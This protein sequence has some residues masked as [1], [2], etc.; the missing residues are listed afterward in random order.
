MIF[1]R[2]PLTTRK[3]FGMLEFR[4]GV[5]RAWAGKGVIYFS[6]LAARASGS[7]IS[8]FAALPEYQNVTIRSWSTT[9]KLHV[10][11]EADD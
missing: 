3:A 9:T 10:L 5:D 4:D 6:R 7:R 8:K 2:K 1:I 11:M